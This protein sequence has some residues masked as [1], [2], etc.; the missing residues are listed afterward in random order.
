MTETEILTALQA[1]DIAAL[2]CVIEQYSGYVMAVVE[3]TLGRSMAQEDKEE[4]VS[5]T[6]VALWKNAA[7][8]K[9]GSRLK[10]WLAVVA[11]HAAINK[12]RSLHPQEELQEDF[13][14]MDNADVTA[15]VEQAELGEIV[16]NA[17]DDL[18]SEDQNIFLRHYY[19]Q[20]SIP[21]I[22]AETGINPS[23]I[24]SRLFRGRQTL[25]AVLTQKGYIL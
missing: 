24:K 23:T 16:R 6:F 15:P 12:A 11:R 25:K 3:H 2:E 5:D 19:W 9:P 22:A 13:I 20:Q 7:N 10:P 21:C 18:N 8:L 4:L 1:N 17:M 14:V